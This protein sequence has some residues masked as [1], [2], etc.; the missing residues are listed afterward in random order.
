MN[1]REWLRGLGLGE[2]ERNFRANKID[3]DVLPH[4]PP[5]T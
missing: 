3:A 4:L 2:Y 1:I 5:T